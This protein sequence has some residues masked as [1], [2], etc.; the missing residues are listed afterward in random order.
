MADTKVQNSIL[1]T[2]YRIVGLGLLLNGFRLTYNSGPHVPIRRSRRSSEFSHHV[3]VMSPL[4]QGFRPMM[5]I[6]LTCSRISLALRNVSRLSLA[7]AL[8]LESVVTTLYWPIILLVPEMMI[9]PHQGQI[10]IPLNVDLAVHLYPALLLWT[11]YF[12][13]SDRFSN[14]SNG[15]IRLA[16]GIQLRPLTLNVLIAGAYVSR[17]EFVCSL[18]SN[19]PFPYPFLNNHGFAVRLP[20]YMASAALSYTFSSLA[21]CLHDY[22]VRV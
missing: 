18:N 9:D 21:E 17:V 14:P 1:V 12:L 4:R 16:E 20:I 2:S 10:T 3:G 11:E 19:I 13:F 5:F 6:L 15:K 7:I 8:P 22:F